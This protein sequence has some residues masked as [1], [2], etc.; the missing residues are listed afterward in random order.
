MFNINTTSDKAIYEQIID[1][2]KELTLKKTLKPEDKLP[3]VREMASM[4]SVNPNTVSKA[5]RELERQKITHTIRGRGTFIS[6]DTDLTIDKERV[7]RAKENLRNICIELGHLG[8]D[9]GKIIEEIDMIYLD[10]KKGGVK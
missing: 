4:I 9:K 3:S 6:P 7:A 2:I 1:N 8:F 5:Y 10:I